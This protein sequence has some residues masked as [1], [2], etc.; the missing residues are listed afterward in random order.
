MKK[1]S[2][3][4]AVNE[5]IAKGDEDEFITHRKFDFEGV[6]FIHDALCFAF[7]PDGLEDDEELD[8]RFLALWGMCLATAG[9]DE[10]EF[11]DELHERRHNE[12]CPECGSPMEEILPTEETSTDKKP[13]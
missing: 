8:N 1:D 9:W 12:K 13:N 5:T 11:W 7:Y 4:T 2:L 10:G 6:E 3:I